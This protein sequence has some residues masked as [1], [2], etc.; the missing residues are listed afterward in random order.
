MPANFDV[1]AIQATLNGVKDAGAGIGGKLVGTGNE[2]LVVLVGIMISWHIL[3][4]LLDGTL[5][6][7]V[8][9]VINTIFVGLIAASFLNN[10]ELVFGFLNEGLTSLLAPLGSSADF[11]GTLQKILQAIIDIWNIKTWTFNP[12][13]PLKSIGSSLEAIPAGALKIIATIAMALA[14]AVYVIMLNIGDFLLYVAMFLGPVMVPWLVISE[15]SFLFSGWLRFALGAAMYKV[16]GTTVAFIS[17]G[18]FAGISAASQTASHVEPGVWLPFDWMAALMVV[19]WA[20]VS[21]YLMFQIPDISQAL[22]GGASIGPSARGLKGLVTGGV[23]TA[24]G[25]TKAAGV[26]G[27]KFEGWA[28]QHSPSTA[29]AIGAARGAKEAVSAGAHK[30]SLGMIGKVRQANPGES[31]TKAAKPS[32]IARDKMQRIKANSRR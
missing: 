26:A 25:L 29:K 4:M 27:S 21:V 17:S 19:F 5:Q 6:E 24:K 31:A 13:H 8:S 14:M 32:Q 7:T 2:L 9:K 22:V 12:L 1:D 18:I 20:L 3:N 30:Y 16:V 10:W 23:G 15:A 28:K 11:Q